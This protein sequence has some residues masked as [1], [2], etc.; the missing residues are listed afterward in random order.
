[1]QSKCP[2][3][4]AA[5]GTFC[6]TRGSAAMSGRGWGHCL[7]RQQCSSS[8]T[9]PSPKGDTQMGE[10]LQ[11]SPSPLLYRPAQCDSAEQTKSHFQRHLPA[12]MAGPGLRSH[13]FTRGVTK[14]PPP[15][16]SPGPEREGTPR[17]RQPSVLPSVTRHIPRSDAGLMRGFVRFPAPP[18]RIQPRQFP[19]SRN[20][21]LQGPS[22][23]TQ[24][25][26]W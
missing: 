10:R 15:R 1:M 6:F 7:F 9:P 3:A 21:T 11:I 5:Q 26:E 18:H 2:S 14:G 13:P 22:V 17:H 24:R 19:S 16:R 23:M 25:F 20:V 12:A 8:G 4:S